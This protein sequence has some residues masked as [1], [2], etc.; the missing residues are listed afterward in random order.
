M[1]NRIY[2]YWAHI[3]RNSINFFYINYM[4]NAY[5]IVFMSFKMQYLTRLLWYVCFELK[6]KII[7]FVDWSFILFVYKFFMNLIEM[8]HV[9]III[10]Q[11]FSE[12]NEL[13]NFFNDKN[14]DTMTLLTSQQTS[15][16]S[17]NF[18][19]VC[20]FM[21]IIKNF[22]FVNDVFQTLNRIFR[23]KQFFIQKI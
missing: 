20:R 14:N 21:I 2:L 16:F 4:I 7:I 15:N 5:Y 13:I 18:Q 1:K 11:K 8:K 3:I 12:R 17:F 19:F 9:I 6:K 10:S 22:A 23:I